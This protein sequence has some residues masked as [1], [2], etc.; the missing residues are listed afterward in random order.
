VS[1]A[2][3]IQERRTKVQQLTNEAKALYATLESQGDKASADDRAK[4]ENMIEVGT[5]AR[6]DLEHLM[7]LEASDVLV[8]RPA[9]AKAIARV[10]GG[11]EP[12]KTWGQKVIESKEFKENNGR[13]LRPVRVHGEQKAVVVLNEGS[14]A[15]GG[16]LFRSE[17]LTEVFDVARQRPR[18]LI[19]LVNNSQ[20]V[21]NAVEYVRM[22]A[23]QN[24]AAVAPEATSLAAPTKPQG[25]LTFD[26][27]TAAVK[28]IAEWIV[29]SRQLLQDA[30]RLADTV[31]NELIYQVQF[32]LEDQ[33][34]NGDGIGNN[35]L[36]ILATPGIQLRVM[37]AGGGTGRAQ[38]AGD[39]RAT[40]LRR[41]ITD[42]RLAFYEPTGIAMNPGDSEGMELTEYG[43]NRFM[44]SFDPVTMRVWRV[45]V[46]ET[47]VLA[48]G[49][50]ITG[51][52]KLGATLWDRMEAD[53][54]TSENV[55]SQFIQNLITV[56]AELR[57]AFGVPRPLCFEKVTLI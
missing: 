36:G 35:F 40:T 49:T 46:I 1:Y 43:A 11:A 3:Q 41:S 34:V 50:A 15:T 20:T 12:R 13:E 26:L 23:R 8:N 10:I 21:S 25:D 52:W 48:A 9:E 39:T 18:T 54:R 4:L 24:M 16:A 22:T 37:N 30:P 57:A 44:L 56:L 7:E 42:I 32:A 27:Q 55:G 53:V 51:A 19:D 6:K 38:V 29:A 2:Q 14:A 31:D 28:T 45:P 33:I 17:R 47:Q 5:T